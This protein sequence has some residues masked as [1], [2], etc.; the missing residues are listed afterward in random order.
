[1]LPNSEEKVLVLYSVQSFFAV[2]LILFQFLPLTPSH[3]IVGFFLA[4]SNDAEA[5]TDEQESRLDEVVSQFSSSHTATSSIFPEV[6]Q[7]PS[8]ELVSSC[9]EDTKL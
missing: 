3:P 1:M 5:Q 4:T 8:M 9:P 7:C 6:K 2:T